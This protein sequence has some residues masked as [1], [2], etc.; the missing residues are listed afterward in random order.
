[1]EGAGFISPGLFYFDK[2]TT[3]TVPP[4]AIAPSR[5]ILEERDPRSARP[6]EAVVRLAGSTQ[7]QG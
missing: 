3:S 5:H 7:H 2:A 6:D 4:A 1:M